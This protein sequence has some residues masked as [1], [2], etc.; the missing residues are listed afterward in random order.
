ML[1]VLVVYARALPCLP[2]PLSRWGALLSYPTGS[3]HLVSDELIGRLS[4]A[5]DH[6]RSTAKTP[7]PCSSSGKHSTP[8][9]SR[10]PAVTGPTPAGVPVMI[11]SP[12]ATHG[13][14]ESALGVV[15]AP[16]THS[17]APL[18]REARRASNDGRA[19]TCHAPAGVSK[20]GRALRWS[21]PRSTLA[22][23]GHRAWPRSHSHLHARITRVQRHYA[24]GVGRRTMSE[25]CFTSPSRLSQIRPC[26][27]CAGPVVV[28]AAGTI[29]PHLRRATHTGAIATAPPVATHIPPRATDDGPGGV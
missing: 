26:V 18:S 7:S 21:P 1:G 2:R 24:G 15:V 11:R 8:A 17:S 3:C 12:C 5:P 20:A 10:C 14:Y 27:G 13:T 6:T 4:R 29:G 16:A 9:S 23:P 19:Q 28:R 22:A 25:S